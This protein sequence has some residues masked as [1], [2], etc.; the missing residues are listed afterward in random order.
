MSLTTDPTDALV[1]VTASLDEQ[2][3]AIADLVRLREATAVLEATRVA[4]AEQAAEGGRRE[5]REWIDAQGTHLAR[6]VSAGIP[7]G[8]DTLPPAPWWSPARRAGLDRPLCLLHV[9]T[10]PDGPHEPSDAGDPVVGIALD[11]ETLLQVSYGP[12]TA[13]WQRWGLRSVASMSATVGTLVVAAAVGQSP[14][15]AIYASALVLGMIATWVADRVLQRPAA[16]GATPCDPTSLTGYDPE[17][18]RA[19]VTRAVERAHGALEAERARYA[20]ALGESPAE[21]TSTACTREPA[22]PTVT[23]SMVD[24]VEMLRWFDQD[25]NAH[26]TSRA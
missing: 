17:R 19:V 20:R 25:G 15:A 6:F 7:V 10:R 21:S 12:R 13:R 3:A 1:S 2:V 4:E 24:G 11:G 8:I 14:S 9:A 5:I 22:S 23:R 26:W 18:F 16:N